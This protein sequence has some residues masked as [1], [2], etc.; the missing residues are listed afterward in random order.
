MQ[1]DGGTVLTNA[2]CTNQRS[3]FTLKSLYLT[4][5][6]YFGSAI[7]YSDNAQM[8]SKYGIKEQINTLQPVQ[9]AGMGTMTDVLTIL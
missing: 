5:R 8:T 4:N 1:V 3:T 2:V 7:V 6:L 9:V